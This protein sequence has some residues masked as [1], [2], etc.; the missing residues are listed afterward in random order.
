METLKK[1]VQE[2]N[3]V[4]SVKMSGAEAVIRCLLEEG[5]TLAYGYP[6]GA[7][8]PVYDELYKYREQ[9]HHVLSRHEQGAIHS[10]Q[11]FARVTGKVGVVFATSGP[12]ATN[13]V[14]GIADAQIDSTP[15]ICIT[16]QVGS[17]LLGSDAFQ[18]TD[19]IGIS[20]PVTKW[21]YQITKAS[22]IPAVFAKA[23]YIAKSGR[24]GPVLIDITK[25]A[26]FGELDFSYN[27][28][29]KV[30]SYKA[31]PTLNIEKVKEAAVLINAAK[32]PMIVFGQGVILGSAENEFKN[33][34][35]KTGIPSACTGL[36]LSALE[37][38]HPLH[39]GMVGMHG[40]YGPNVLT[41]QCD[42]LIAIGMRFDDRVTGNLNTYAKQAKIIHFEIDP[43]EVDKNVKTDV[44]VL[45]T[46]KESLVEVMQ[47]VNKGNHSEWMK[48]FHKLYE[49]EKEV[50][51]NDQLNPTKEGLTMSEVL[52]GI[53]KETK[54]EAVIVSDVG[55]HQ[56][57]AWR[58]AKFTKTR[59][60]ITSGGLG[61]MGFA[62]PAAIG[63]KMGAPDREVIA[64]IGDGGYQMT[65]QEL[66]TILQTKAAVK[67]VVLN[68]SFLG[69]VRQWQE[70]FFDRRY[71]STVMTNP[72]FVKI[73]EGYSI[74]AN[75]VS[76]R[77]DL[78][79]AI[80]KM[81]DSKEAYF[82]EVVIEPES[83]VFP[84]IPTGASVSDIRL[85]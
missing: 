82:L 9:F 26:Q 4:K 20:T 38:D 5:S 65:I 41:N 14:T 13:L 67:I 66:G 22:E 60:N 31:I 30:R 81:T 17:H 58:Y 76:K 7:I 29:V 6:G 84:M 16:G 37:T 2:I 85:T 69:M 83:N 78:A 72:D 1:E 19:I 52:A 35:E 32:K 3:T 80:K 21:N 43:S 44:A 18:E 33:F 28:C 59:S 56:M 62:L 47:F 79:D 46:V 77:E 63:A 68:N 10:A 39:V 55:Q 75:R 74:E 73:A 54:G 36:G 70:L 51:I 50:V 15:L 71:A 48:E 24:P 45:G 27:K 25:D 34:I 53:N 42:V 49:I 11:G 12:G 64:I 8:M 40:N 61:T 23:F 57:I